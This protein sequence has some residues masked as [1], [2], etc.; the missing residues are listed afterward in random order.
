MEH[1]KEG[2]LIHILTRYSSK[3]DVPFSGVAIETEMKFQGD[4][5]GICVGTE[6]DEGCME[7]I[8]WRCRVIAR[9]GRLRLGRRITERAEDLQVTVI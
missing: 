1:D 9:V 7:A 3:Q 8:E 5:E 6:G 2:G 4:V